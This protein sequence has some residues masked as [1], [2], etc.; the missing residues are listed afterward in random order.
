MTFSG[1]LACIFIYPLTLLLYGKDF[2]PLVIPFWILA[3]SIIIFYSSALV[4][5]YFLGSGRPD[6]PLK[7]SLI[8]II[9][10]AFFCYL[11]IPKFGISGAALSASLSF[12]ILSFIQ[13]IV[14]KKFTGLTYREILVTKAEDKKLIYNFIKR[15][16][17]PFFSRN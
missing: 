4:N 1:I 11:F 15:K 16:L 8:P 14:F 9:P 7:I 5:P 12:L 3:P 13:I 17:K 2:I 6:I 10:Q